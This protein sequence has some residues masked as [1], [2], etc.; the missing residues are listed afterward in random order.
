MKIGLFGGTFDPIHN[1]H[2]K[3]AETA[4]AR[5]RLDKIVLVPSGTPP[6]KTGRRVTE[7][8]DR[9]AMAS[10]VA[11]KADL[12]LSAW[13]L[14]REEKSYSVDMVKHF[15][16]VYEGDELYFIVGADSFY[17]LPAWYR[18]QELMELCTFVVVSRP[19]TEREKLLERFSGTEKPPRAFFLDGVCVDISSTEIRNRI[20]CGQDIS[21]LVPPE[22]LQYIKRQ[23]LYR[24]E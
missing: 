24:E 11:E 8:K 15:R 3:V 2:L 20:R 13:E 23:G 17:N 6:H 22:V 18:Y 10:L 5:L 1:G 16:S 14:E 19:E 21:S 4:K 12:L 9:L 7:K